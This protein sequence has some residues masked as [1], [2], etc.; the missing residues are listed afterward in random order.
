[1]AG[2]ESINKSTT[3]GDAA[4]DGLLAG[5]GA[6]L[7]ML[8]YWLASGLLTGGGWSSWL[9]A[10]DLSG[11]MLPLTGGLT[12]LA[13]AAV[14]GVLFGAIVWLTPRPVRRR[15]RGWPLALGYTLVLLLLAESLF[16]PRLDVPVRSIP[17]HQMLLGHGVYGLTLGWLINS[18]GAFSHR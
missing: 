11:A 9:A 1:M 5:L 14:Y 10:F 7:L 6:G 12:I 8:L 15:L 16:L 3:I 17:L 2:I 4:V 13:I 18:T